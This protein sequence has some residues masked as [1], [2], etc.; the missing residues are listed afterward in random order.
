[1]IE[2]KYDDHKNPSNAAQ[3]EDY[4]RSC[5]K[6]KCKFI[7]LSQ[8]IPPE[9]LPRKLPGNGK[10]LLFSDLAHKLLGNERSVGGMLRQFFVDRG[11]VMHRFEANDLANLKSFL[12]RLLNPWSGQGRSQ[13]KDAMGGGAA[14][15][16]GNLL[17]NMNIIAKEVTANAHSR[18]PTI[19]FELEPWVKKREI[20]KEISENPKDPLPSAYNAKGGGNL[21]VFGRVRLDDTVRNWVQ[22]EFGIGLEVNAGDRDFYPFTYAAVYGYAYKKFEGGFA[23][24]YAPRRVLHDKQRAVA[25]LKK[26]IREAIGLA[27]NRTPPKNQ[28]VKL[29]KFRNSLR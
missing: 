15:A 17:R 26:R 29:K 24:E 8:H 11:L 4:T 22:I 10:L 25:E 6:H 9:H 18:T 23:H 3:L 20:Q 16:F 5:K 14:E 19:D 28:I 21:S 1:L 27:I 7:F 13:N 12:F 2:I